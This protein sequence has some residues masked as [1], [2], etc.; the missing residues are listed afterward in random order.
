MGKPFKK[1]IE[2]S[3]ATIEW[4]FQQNIEMVYS[5]IFNDISKPLFI[6]GSGGSLSACQFVALLYQKLGT[7]AKAITPL[8]LYYS[9]NS[10]NKSK[11]LL[12][13][14]S[15]KNNDILFAFNIALQNH[16]SE[17]TT[18]CMRKDAPLT[19][20][21]NSFS[22]SKGLE[23]DIPTKKDGFL[24]TNSLTAFFTIF[25]K[26]SGYNFQ[27]K[28]KI[29]ENFSYKSDISAFVKKLKFDS[30]IIVL[31]GGWATPIAF[32][33][34]SKFTEAALGSILLADFRNFGHG[35]HHWF[36]KRKN[37]S[38]IVVLITPEEKKIAN[39][40]LSLIPDY[41]P[42]LILTSNIEGAFSSIELLIQTYHLVNSV[43]EEFNIDP[44]RPGVPDFGRKLY[45]LKYSSFYPKKKNLSLTENEEHAILR[46][47]NKSSILQL[48]E[49][50]LIFWK[51]KYKSYISNLSKTNF[52][53]IVFDY[54]GTLCSSEERFCGY[55]PKETTIHLITLLKAGITIGIAT[56]RGQSVKQDLQNSK[57]PKSYWNKIIIGYYNGADI[58]SL[59]D[60]SCPNTKVT[61]NKKLSHLN[62]YIKSLELPY[63]DLKIKLRPFQL[64]IE[65]SD[66]NNWKMIKNIIQNIVMSKS[67]GELQLLESSHSIDVVV[68]NKA[69]KLNV[70]KKVIE[71]SGN[72]NCLTIGDKGQW[73]GND[74]ELLST[75][76]S[77]SV[78]D[79]SAH[80]DS[81]WNISSIGSKNSEATIEY[82]KRIKLSNGKFKFN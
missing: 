29:L 63:S 46:K 82:L 27:S 45:H 67:D 16:V 11:V 30:S 22:V 74:F 20:I 72:S 26:S 76:F 60:D 51:M 57:I 9:K 13:S 43:G 25:A 8:E 41:I 71:V 42:R 81:C 65:V 5:R 37:N 17:I 36:A 2:E 79:V 75:P 49:K 31:H 15:G 44:G 21:A 58:G 80:P 14:S 28:N 23:F 10:L 19:K 54:D 61:P 18:I 1:E 62:E 52:S 3:Y 6:V 4:A 24:A 55:L 34:E 50:E 35:R 12:I 73:P 33:I 66:P 40:T 53:S 39:S 56:G 48:E 69:S 64:T 68:R 32:D 77:L 78:D 59:N 38:V 70:V 7:V 47:T